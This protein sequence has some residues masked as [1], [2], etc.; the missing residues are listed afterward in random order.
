[1]IGMTVVAT[2]PRAPRQRTRRVTGV[3]LSA[4]VALALVT[5]L[6][7]CG[8]SGGGD[9]QASEKFCARLG[10]DQA[11]LRAVLSSKAETDAAIAA[12]AALEATAPKGLADDL[13]IMNS[14]YAQ[15]AKLDFSDPKQR[16]QALA[17]IAVGTPTGTKFA[18]ASL[19]IETYA[20]DTCGIDLM[21]PT[22]V[23]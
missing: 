20:K 4:A 9:K 21:A 2:D 23:G 3:A 11:T 17:L 18:Q 6:T 10:T 8:G 5:T 15:L 7:A 19:N 22:T 1:M 12:Y 14:T 16:N 13:K